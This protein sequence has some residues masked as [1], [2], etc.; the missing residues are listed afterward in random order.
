[1][2]RLFIVLLSFV[3]LLSFNSCVSS[4]TLEPESLI[5]KGEKSDEIV[6]TLSTPHETSTRAEGNPH[7]GYKL[8]YVAKLF[9][10]INGSN[11]QNDGYQ[12]AEIIENDENENK[13]IFKVPHYD[14]EIKKYTIIVFADYIPIDYQSENGK[15]KDYFYNTSS[16]DESIIMNSTPASPNTNLSPSFFNNDNYDCFGIVFEAYKDAKKIEET[17]EL[18]R[19]VAKVEWY[20]NSGNIN[21][22]KEINFSKF[23]IYNQ[24]KIQKNPIL[25][26]N[27]PFEWN[28]TGFTNEDLKISETNNNLLF[29]F[30]TF[31][32]SNS[33]ARLKINFNS[34]TND[35]ETPKSVSS[36][37]EGIPIKTN[38]ITKV[39]GILLP[40]NSTDT[41]ED[42][43]SVEDENDLII[44]HVSKDDVWPDDNQLSSEVTE[45]TSNSN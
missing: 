16:E 2:K 32:G 45:S 26:G 39:T 5:V 12:R 21:N 15:F 18:K 36:K 41:P 13:I 17:I 11:L 24:L 37:D 14:S 43:P 19:L 25:I 34:F 9:P 3:T 31:A 27:N 6:L 10:T 44:L 8:R 4:E 29:F 33:N 42:G 35:L 40:S 30:Y 23:E 7:E 20:D 28:S 22:F 38:Y 1:M